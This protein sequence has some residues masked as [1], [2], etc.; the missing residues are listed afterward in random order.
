MQTL[1]YLKLNMNYEMSDTHVVTISIHCSF[2]LMFIRIYLTPLTTVCFPY[3]IT[4]NK[5]LNNTDSNN[6]KPKVWVETDHH[7]TENA[8]DISD[9]FILDGNNEVCI[10]V[11]KKVFI[12]MT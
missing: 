6:I 11:K 7:R 3:L 5:S 10:F 9:N 2:H 8:I 1:H 4:D 12:I